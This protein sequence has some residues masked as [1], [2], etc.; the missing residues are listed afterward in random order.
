[1]ISANIRVLYKQYKSVYGPFTKTRTTNHHQK[2]FK[3][4]KEGSTRKKKGK[5]GVGSSFLGFYVD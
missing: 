5:K 2:E 4:K 3:K 1:V